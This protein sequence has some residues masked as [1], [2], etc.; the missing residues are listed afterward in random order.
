M[1]VAGKFDCSM[2]PQNK[3]LKG[4]NETKKQDTLK[5]SRMREEGNT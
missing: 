5:E 1:P 3:K 4:M 2:G